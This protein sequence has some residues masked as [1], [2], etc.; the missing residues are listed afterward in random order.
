MLIGMHANISPLLPPTAACAMPRAAL[1]CKTHRRP[2]S[3]NYRRNDTNTSCAQREWYINK[4]VA[5]CPAWIAGN[6]RPKHARTPP[7]G[8]RRRHGLQTQGVRRVALH[9]SLLQVPMARI[10]Y[11]AL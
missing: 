3:Y 10:L 5:P 1:H 8:V 2:G 9:V 4:S 6:V 11:F 7:V